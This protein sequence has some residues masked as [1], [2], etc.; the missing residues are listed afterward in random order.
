MVKMKKRL[1]I[2]LIV[3]GIIAA[4]LIVKAVLLITAK[5][6]VTVDYVAEYNRITYPENYDP[7]DNAAPYY[8]KAYDAFV[9]MPNELRSPYI[10]WPT[11]YIDF[12]Q[13]R[14]ESWVASNSRAFEFFKIAANKSV[15]WLERYPD[16]NNNMLSIMFPELSPLKYL[17]EALLW[18]AKLEAYKG[19]LQ[20]TF[21]N[22]IDCYK[23][24]YQKCRTP[25]F[26][27]EQL[28]GI[29]RKRVALDSALLI[30]DK[31]HID[32]STLKSFQ[33]ALQEQLDKDTY[34]LDFEAE[35]MALYDIL[36]MTFVDNGRG[37]GRL[38]WS[39]VKDFETMCGEEENSRLKRKL[40][41]KCFFGPTRNDMVIRIE[42]TFASFEALKT[43]TPW[44]LHTRDPNY[45]KRLDTTNH[46]DCDDCDDFILDMFFPAT[47]GPFNTYHQV[48]IKGKALLAIIAI[49]RFKAEKG[50]LP[51]TLDELVDSGYLQSVP[52]DPYSNGPLVYKLTEDNFKLYSVG[53]DFSDNGGV[54]EIRTREESRS[55]ETHTVPY[56]YSP[57]IV[58]WP[59]KDLM[60][61]RNEH[62]IETNKIRKKAT[63]NLFILYEENAEPNQ[64]S[65]LKEE[66]W[67]DIESEF[68]KYPEEYPDINKIRRYKED[69]WGVIEEDAKHS[70]ENTDQ[71]QPQTE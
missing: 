10:N 42:K 51:A 14:L 12:E 3:I 68:A 30:L 26:L 15:Y 53:E 69:W 48:R 62:G 4:I 56:V 57:D 5:P 38:S 52:M 31:T 25:S 13:P 1:H 49:H 21:D 40:L 7:N 37:T 2:F 70:L 43:E 20:T 8:Q 11:D 55:N 16:E 41:L 45:F 35:R 71:N 46:G 47:F 67:K 24:G 29:G 64:I 65:Q 32:N 59:Y 6:K 54:V 28:V 50:M 23:A 66:W 19:R 63:R 36:Q 33:T 60:K 18:N 44:Q 17:S 22:I 58:Y 61:L 39:V 34:I 9:K 27:I